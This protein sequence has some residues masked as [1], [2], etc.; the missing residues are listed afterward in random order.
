[1]KTNTIIT[2][3]TYALIELLDIFDINNSAILRLYTDIQYN[4][5]RITL[6][7]I[8]LANIESIKRKALSL[9]TLT[10]KNYTRYFNFTTS[11]LKR[12]R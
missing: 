6:R 12:L 5:I 10:T 4:T 1:M 3:S 11:V 2:I 8:I 7:N 9:N